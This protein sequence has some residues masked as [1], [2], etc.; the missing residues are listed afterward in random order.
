MRKN[1]LLLVDDH[2]IVCLGVEALL[3]G[4]PDI[5]WLGACSNASDTLARAGDLQ[6]EVIV[7]DLMLG[8]R[9]G[10]E[11][12]GSLLKAAPATRI[13]IF[14]AL[15][16]R[17]HARRAFSAGAHGYVVKEAGFVAL[18]KAIRSV[19]AGEP[20]A[21]DRVKQGLLEEAIGRKPDASTGA[22][23]RLSNQELYVFRL[24]GSGLGSAE[25]AAK[26]G[27]SQK[28]VSTHRER[29]K[30]KLGIHTARELERKAEQFFRE[31][32]VGLP[33]PGETSR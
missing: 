30:N 13:V 24:L 4:A 19:A 10:L 26:L 5:E 20:Y 22:V 29:I 1:S 17:T 18:L 23:D 28:T 12:I 11:L 15:D 16:E 2:P 6:P 14:S 8:G 21:S 33:V 31:G 25:I 9:D 3:K 27:I 7:L 32:S